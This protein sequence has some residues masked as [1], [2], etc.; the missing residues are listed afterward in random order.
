MSSSQA[1]QRRTSI[2]KP[3]SPCSPRDPAGFA[4]AAHSFAEAYATLTKGEYAPFQYTAD[5][6]RAALDGLRAIVGLAGLTPAQTFDTIRHYAAGGGI[7][8]RLYDALIGQV[9]GV[10]G[11]PAI[12]TWNTKHMARLF[13]GVD[14]VTPPRYLRARA[15]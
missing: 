10:H 9:A 1:L 13:P 3:L 6:A 2:T 15:P 5:D 8:S 7:D 12:V 14:V 11:I 4:I